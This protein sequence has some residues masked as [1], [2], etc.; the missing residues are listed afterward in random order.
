MLPE[1]NNV[2]EP[3]LL[4][5]T[6]LTEYEPGLLKTIVGFD[7]FAVN[8]VY[9]VP[10]WKVQTY[11]VG[12]LDTVAENVI[13]VQASM[14]CTVGLIEVTTGGCKIVTNCVV[15]VQEFASLT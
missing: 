14:L 12:L 11:D 7:P 9:G 8:T 13:F 4:E 5:A 2:L 6:K 1:E 3:A 10:P 15:L